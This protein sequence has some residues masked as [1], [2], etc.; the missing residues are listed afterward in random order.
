MKIVFV[1]SVSKIFNEQEAEGKKFLTH[2]QWQHLT[3]ERHDTY[4]AAEAEI[5]ADMAKRN[6]PEYYKIDKYFVVE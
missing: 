4:P 6:T 1:V 2:I 3:G 5:Q